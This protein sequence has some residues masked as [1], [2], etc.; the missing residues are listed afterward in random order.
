[1]CHCGDEFCDMRPDDAWPWATEEYSRL[2]H[3][4]EWKERYPS[5]LDRER[6]LYRHIRSEVI[7]RFG[8][9]AM[10]FEWRKVA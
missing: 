5:G 2:F 10:N 9:D 4:A 8:P 7:S 6:A 1:M 3:S